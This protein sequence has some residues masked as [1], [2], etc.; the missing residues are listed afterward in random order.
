MATEEEIIIEDD[1]EEEDEEEGF[2]DLCTILNVS[3][4]AIDALQE[5]EEGVELLQAASTYIKKKTEDDEQYEEALNTYQESAEQ[6]ENEYS[7]FFGF[8][9]SKGLLLS[10]LFAL[11]D[12]CSQRWMAT[13]SSLSGSNKTL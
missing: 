7:E 2:K 11:Q 3:E 9:L 10:M 8:F 6:A 13:R 5:S 12:L 4:E 1:D